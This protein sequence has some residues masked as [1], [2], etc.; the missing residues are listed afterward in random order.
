MYRLKNIKI[1]NLSCTVSELR[2]VQLSEPFRPGNEVKCPAVINLANSYYTA[3]VYI[4]NGGNMR[5][6]YF[7]NQGKESTPLDNFIVR[8]QIC[9]L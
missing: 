4:Y 8:T 5:C 9:Y 2:N 7:N 1:I 3:Y 6:Y